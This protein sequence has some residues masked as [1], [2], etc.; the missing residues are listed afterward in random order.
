MGSEDAF[1]APP[2]PPK[3]GRYASKTGDETKK[4]QIPRALALGMTRSRGAGVKT[5]SF[6]GGSARLKSSPVTKRFIKMLPVEGAALRDS[7]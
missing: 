5:P 1:I 4:K 3:G 7:G 2:H 6:G